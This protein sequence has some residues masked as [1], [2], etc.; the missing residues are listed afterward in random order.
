[1]VSTPL[2]GTTYVLFTA[3]LANWTTEQCPHEPKVPVTAV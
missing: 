1:L 2:D 3:L